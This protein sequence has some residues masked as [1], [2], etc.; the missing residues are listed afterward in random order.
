MDAIDEACENIREEYDNPAVDAVWEEMDVRH[1]ISRMEGRSTALRKSK[2]DTDADS[3]LTQWVWRMCRFHSGA[4][5]KMP[6]TADF[7]LDSWLGDEGIEAKVMG[8][9]TDVEAENGEALKDALNDLVTLI[10][11]AKGKD[12]AGGAK[13]W[14]G[15]L[16]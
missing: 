7:W 15:L 2:P 16:F 4:D 8:V 11:L 9:K 1:L 3:G 13:R 12:P 6:V 5:P 14:E 10:L